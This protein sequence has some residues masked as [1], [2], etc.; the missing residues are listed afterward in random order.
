V[1]ASAA[2]DG[3][4]PDPILARHA[5]T[6]DVEPRTIDAVLAAFAGFC[7]TGGLALA[8]AGLHAIADAKIRLGGATV[9]WLARRLRRGDRR[10]P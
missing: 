3:I 9:G 5:L 7:L 6:T 2:T 8:P 1:L 10:C 4:D